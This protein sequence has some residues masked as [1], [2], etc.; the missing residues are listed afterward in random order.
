MEKIELK[1]GPYRGL[2]TQVAKALGKR[3]PNVYAAIF[4][5]D[6]MNR[7]KE[8]FVQF[9]N[10]RDVKVLSFQNAIRQAV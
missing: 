4:Y 3:Q 5:T 6:E 10:E 1:K 8:L 9:K 2:I 7:E